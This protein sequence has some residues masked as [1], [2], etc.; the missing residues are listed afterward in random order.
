MPLT[1]I[2]AIRQHCI[3]CMGGQRSEVKRCPLKGCP[4]YPYRMGHRPKTG[5]ETDNTE[6]GTEDKE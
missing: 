4:L 1:P 6:S 2:K 5:T 3:E